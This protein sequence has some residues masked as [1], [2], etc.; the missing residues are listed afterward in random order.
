MRSYQNLLKLAF[1]RWD[2]VQPH[3]PN[4]NNH[5]L[6]KLMHTNTQ[7]HLY[8]TII[9]FP[10]S[11]LIICPHV[12]IPKC[13]LHTWNYL[14]IINNNLFSLIQKHAHLHLTE[15]VKNDFQNTMDIFYI[16][17]VALTSFTY[18]FP[19]SWQKTSWRT[20]HGGN[21]LS[22]QRTQHEKGCDNTC[23][24]FRE[25]FKLLKHVFCYFVKLSF[26]TSL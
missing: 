15:V 23:V 16:F 1:V 12:K 22:D 13:W 20:Q 8:W 19:K 21:K 5:K 4:S 2:G 10:I 24:Q 17:V 26:S 11:F 9:F 3:N 25:N 6:L 18:N 14:S 7:N